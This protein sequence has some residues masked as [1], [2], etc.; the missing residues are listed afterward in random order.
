MASQK[1]RPARSAAVRSAIWHAHTRCCAIACRATSRVN[2]PA[3]KS[4]EICIIG[5]HDAHLI[6]LELFD[7]IANPT[8][9][10]TFQP[11]ISSP[12]SPIVSTWPFQTRR[13]Q[14]PAQCRCDN[15]PARR[16]Y[17][18]RAVYRFGQLVLQSSTGATGQA[19]HL[20]AVREKPGRLA[21]GPEEK[22]GFAGRMAGCVN[23]V[24]SLP[25]QIAAP[26]WGEFPRTDIVGLSRES[27]HR[28]PRLPVITESVNHSL[29]TSE[30]KKRR[31]RNSQTSQALSGAI[32]SA[33]QS[34]EKTPCQTGP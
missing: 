17:G 11:R 23:S 28:F 10:E 20:R 12:R 30:P 26:R 27:K 9:A 14:R 6:Q 15:H 7:G 3:T 32:Q 8:G 22:L 31:E 25:F 2:P 5:F 34:P 24:I 19:R 13:Y 33:C 16:E 1:V 21:H 4:D 29:T 18:A